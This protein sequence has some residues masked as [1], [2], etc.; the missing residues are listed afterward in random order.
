MAPSPLS[1]MILSS[2]STARKKEFHLVTFGLSSWREHTSE[3]VSAA[4]VDRPD[5]FQRALHLPNVERCIFLYGSLDIAFAA[6]H[7][8]KF[9]IN[10]K[11]ECKNEHEC[12]VWLTLFTAICMVLTKSDTSLSLAKNCP[13][14]KGVSIDLEGKDIHYCLLFF[15]VASTFTKENWNGT[16]GQSDKSFLLPSAATATIS[17][18]Q[19]GQ[20]NRESQQRWFSKAWNV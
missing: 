4:C 16:Y 8:S 2:L 20:V 11:M 6:K 7:W 3:T 5:L 17:G 13:L 18:V 12:T 19:A 9:Q 14:K 15:T 10:F 1:L